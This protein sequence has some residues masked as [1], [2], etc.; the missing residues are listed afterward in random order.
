MYGSGVKR[1]TLPSKRKRIA[2]AQLSGSIGRLTRGRDKHWSREQKLAELATTTTDPQVLGDAMGPL[3][4][5]EH[6]DFAAADAEGLELLRTLGADETHARAIAGWI[7][8]KR[9]HDAA[10]PGPVM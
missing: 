8:W 2:A 6:A 7:R 9:G 4:V 3:L 10:A 1:P 5:E